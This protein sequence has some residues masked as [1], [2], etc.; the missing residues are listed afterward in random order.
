MRAFHVQG[1]SFLKLGLMNE[2]LP[3]RCR[4]VVDVAFDF[5]EE[6]G[7]FVGFPV[8][9]EFFVKAFKK[10]DTK[11][12]SKRFKGLV[13]LEGLRFAGS[14]RSRNSFHERALLCYS[15]SKP[16]KFSSFK[17]SKNKGCSL[18]IVPSLRVAVQ[19]AISEQPLDR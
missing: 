1:K 6:L 18:F 5:V 15:R 3:H 19:Q 14:G 10:V 9:Q 13:G 2:G 7:E 17:M 11:A 12:A 8:P 4:I 16:R